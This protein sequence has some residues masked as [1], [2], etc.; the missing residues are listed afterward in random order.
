LPPATPSKEVVVKNSSTTTAP[1]SGSVKKNFRKFNPYHDPHN[2]QFTTAEGAGQSDDDDD[3]E[4]D[5]DVD[6]ASDTANAI[7]DGMNGASRL[8]SGT[9]VAGI[10]DSIA[11]EIAAEAQTRTQAETQNENTE[12]STEGNTAEAPTGSVSETLGEIGDAIRAAPYMGSDGILLNAD[13]AVIDPN[14]IIGYSLNPDNTDGSNKA[15]VFNSVLGYN[16]SNADGLIQQLQQGVKQYP[17]TV[18]KIDN[19]GTRFAVNIP[20][21]GPN[22]NTAKVLS[23]WI[24]IQ[25]LI[26]QD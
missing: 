7:V 20:V 2:G 24:Y 26:S 14:K 15:V 6:S 16:Q 5:T 9:Q 11:A 8:G 23:A 4:S 3:D 10:K 13:S 1:Q 12:S 22:G 21:T 17:A 18:G 25:V 19:F